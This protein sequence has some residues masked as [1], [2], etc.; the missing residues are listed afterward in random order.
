MRM[1]TVW[2]A[3][4][5]PVIA[6]L[7]WPV[8]AAQS[9]SPFHGFLLRL[10]DIQPG[11][12]VADVGAGRGDFALLAAEKVGPEGHVYANEISR[13]KVGQ[14]EKQKRA[15]GAANLT[16]ILGE[17]EDPRLPAKVDYLLMVQVF[18][19]LSRPD[20]FMKNTLQYLKPDGRLVV[21]AVL[22][23]RNPQA[24]PRTS[25]QNDPCV[26]DPE[27]TKRAIERMGF[28]FEQVAFHDNPNTKA[29]W[30]TSYVLIF[31]TQS[32]IDDGWADWEKQL[33]ARQQ[34]EK[35][36]DIIGL[37]PG[38]VVGEIGAG[39]GR[40]TV[41]LAKRVGP[42][43]RVFANDIDDRALA[44]LRDRVNR[45]KVS[46]IE[47]VPGRVD[48]PCLPR[49][50]LDMAIMVRTYHELAQPG[51]LLDKLKASLQPN[52]TV[53]IVDLDTAKERHDGARS[54]TDE[55][56][57]RSVARSAGYDVVAVHTFLAEDTI[58]VLRAAPGVW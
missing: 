9:V 11:M 20:G 2:K 55:A 39:D 43:G 26:S 14:I 8:S 17:E 28:A 21:T 10:L 41:H 34:P 57:I 33:T 15:R 6:I 49:N 44:D 22:N 4:W 52:A 51:T 3:M 58:F 12:T 27:E 48:D 25:T 7:S 35:V 56:S 32:W 38:M 18:H 19:H 16:V 23:R 31:R 5:L 29:N 37:K 24:Q 54:S 13:D 1:S 45:Y 40:F 53:V 42:G 46:N 30:P 50:A 36:M 47:V